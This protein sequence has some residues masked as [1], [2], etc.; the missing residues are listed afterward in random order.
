MKTVVIFIPWFDPAY[1]A[2]GPVQSIINLVN[3]FKENISYKIFTGVKDVDGSLIEV[4]EKNKWV[5]YN[6][7]TQVWYADNNNPFFDFKKEL[8]IIKPDVIFITGIFSLPFNILP[9]LFS[10]SY[11]LILSVRGM[12]H[13]GA[14]S[15]KKIKKQIF[16]AFLK[17]LQIQKK[18]RFHATDEN[19][20]EFIKDIFGNKSTILIADNFPKKIKPAET[21]QKEENKL[22]LITVALISPMKNYDLIIRALH[23]SKAKI[24]YHIIGGIKDHLY[25]NQCLELIHQLPENIKVVY[26]GE[27]QPQHINNFL[28]KA[29][30]FIMPSKSE[31]YGHAIIE[32]LQSGLP[33]IT[34]THTPWN[35]LFENKAGINVELS[36]TSIVEAIE[37]FSKMNV[38]VYNDWSRATTAYVADA[39]NLSKIQHQYSIM[40]EN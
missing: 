16:I 35:H 2:G 14:L 4:K 3:N 13:P 28:Q 1:K 40:F 26:H 23:Q 7:Y 8:S 33:V 5:Q 29:H 22:I 6:E 39:I 10:N 12:L 36:V 27:Q 32:A 31:N 30:V 24:E 25:W 11:N 9:L 38:Q 34:S 19:E 20:R 15:Q 37:M 18:I 17:V 21:I